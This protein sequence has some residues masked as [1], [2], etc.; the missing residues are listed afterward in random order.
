[1]RNYETK[2]DNSSER[3][4][5]K[6][7]NPVAFWRPDGNLLSK[8]GYF[9]GAKKG[10]KNLV[11]L[12]LPPTHKTKILFLY[13]SQ[14]SFFGCQVAKIYQKE[15]VFVIIWYEGLFA[16]CISTKFYVQLVSI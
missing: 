8:Y 9:V 1:M 15:K 3:K 4:V 11:T 10:L 7:K 6:F 16:I 5:E 14:W 13:K 12:V 2:F